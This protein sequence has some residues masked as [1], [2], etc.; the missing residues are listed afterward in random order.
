M[1][2][3]AF[4]QLPPPPPRDSRS[5]IGS[6]SSRNDDADSP[7]DD[8]DDNMECAYFLLE[9]DGAKRRKKALQIVTDLMERSGRSKQRAADILV[10]I[11]WP[12]SDLFALK[13]DEETTAGSNSQRKTD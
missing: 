5:G 12:D 6:S 4:A 7:E 13:D 10:G 3:W 9:K 1:K 11:L 8:A 2:E